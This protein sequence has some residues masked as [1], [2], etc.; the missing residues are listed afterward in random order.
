[1]AKWCDGLLV[2]L[3]FPL[4]QFTVAGGGDAIY[5]EGNAQKAIPCPRKPPRDFTVGSI[6]A[7]KDKE[8]PCR[9]DFRKTGVRLNPVAD[10]S[11][12]DPGRRVLRDSSGRFHST[13]APGFQSVISVW[14]EAGRYLTSFGRVGEGPGEFSGRGGMTL[15]TDDESKL[16]VRDGAGSWSVFSRDQEFLGRV[17]IRVS[18]ALV[19]ERSAVVL[20][21]GT[22]LGS[23]DGYVS[24]R[25]YYFFF[26]DSAGTLGRT[27][28][29]VKE[30]LSGSRRSLQRPIAYGGGDTFWAGPAEGSKDGYVLEEWGVDGELRRS[31]RRDASW[32]EWRED[33]RASTS[34]LQLHV[35]GGG[36]L[37]V[38][39]SRPTE[40]FVKALREG[41][42]LSRAERDELAEVVLEVIDTKSGELLASETHP[43]TRAREFLP[44]G[45]FR[46]AMLGYR[47]QEGPDGLPFVEMVAVELVAR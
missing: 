16:Y 46:G 24:D 17:P 33:R 31:F 1:M 4:A 36:L 35:G 5:V 10:G 44:R 3:L 21:D 11:R 6:T 19:S 23:N 45:L 13:N 38:M 8:L 29:P 14:D 12:P 28:G 42:R 30:E 47:Y 15:F 34:V 26:V 20:D 40:E 41:R 32:Y 7:I 25:T 27:F 37:Y 9:L 22:A 18:G 2:V 43:N 39:V